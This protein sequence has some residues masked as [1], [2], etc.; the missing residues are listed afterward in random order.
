MASAIEEYRELRRQLEYVRWACLG[1]ESQQE[2]D[3]LDSMDVI[4]SRL[5]G[6]EVVLV[7]SD[8][9]MTAPTCPVTRVREL[10]DVDV[11]A[12]DQPPRALQEAA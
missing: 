5:T 1:H 8:P 10:I 2:D 11:Q 6:D 7:E 9:P 4:W 12:D 3:L